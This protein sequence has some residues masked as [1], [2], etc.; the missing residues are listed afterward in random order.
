MSVRTVTQTMEMA[1]TRLENNEADLRELDSRYYLIDP[2]LRAL[3]WDLSDPAQVKFECQMGDGRIDYVLFNRK[4]N[5]AV[6]MEA[7]RADSWLT[8]ENIVQLR[9]YV[10]RRKQG[11]AVLTNG[12]EWKIYDLSRRGSSIQKEARSWRTFTS[13]CRIDSRKRMSGV[14]RQRRLLPCQ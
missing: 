7:K 2:V 9:E 5:P 10:Q 8:D 11:L 1:L 12:T 3:K 4:G 6:Y 14:K 13:T